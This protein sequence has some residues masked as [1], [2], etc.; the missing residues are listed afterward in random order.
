MLSE[1]TEK[2]LTYD[3]A[4]DLL[5][6]STGGLRNR[7]SRGE[8]MPPTIKIGRRRL[9]PESELHKWL[10]IRRSTGDAL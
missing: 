2:Y 4:A 8:P 5:C 3:Q 10:A 1:R 6:M 7:M 9:F